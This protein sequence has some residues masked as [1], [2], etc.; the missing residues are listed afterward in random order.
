MLLWAHLKAV[1]EAEMIE[2][3]SITPNC[4][5]MRSFEPNLGLQLYYI[6]ICK[7]GYKGT[8]NI[9]KICLTLFL[10]FSFNAYKNR[11]LEHNVLFTIQDNGTALASHPWSSTFTDLQSP[12][13]YFTD[14][15]EVCISP[16]LSV[17]VLWNHVFPSFFA[18]FLSCHCLF[19]LLCC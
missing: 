4:T 16:S 1:S 12:E 13:A 5:S 6:T 18:L 19:C 10:A 2:Y 7:H 3:H 11:K 9:Q 17:S 8:K 14:H 15:F